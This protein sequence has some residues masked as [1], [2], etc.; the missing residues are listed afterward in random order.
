MKKSVAIIGGGPSALLLAAFLDD[1]KFDVSIYEK[2]AA[3]GRKF[4][5]AGKGG[6]NLTHSE[7]MHQFLRRYT[8]SD[9][10]KTAL[11][12]FTNEDLRVWL[13]DIGIETYIGSSKRVY[14]VKGIKPIQVL[15]TFIDVLKKKNVTILLD[16]EWKGWDKSNALLF[17]DSLRINADVVVFAL[18]GG[19]W[20]VT[21]SAGNWLSMFQE[22]GIKTIPFLPSNCAYE[23]DW[24]SAFVTNY[25]GTPLKN[26]ALTCR[27][28][29]QKGEVV[30]TSFG[31]EGNAIYALSPRI[32]A[33]LEQHNK[34]TIHLDLKPSLEFDTVLKKLQS[35][36]GN[37]STRLKQKLKLTPA[38]IALVKNS[39]TK[40]E[41][42]HL[43][44]LTEKIKAIPITI[45]SAGPV[46]AA[47]STVGGVSLD[48]VNKTFEL[49]A[50]PN[51]YCL[52]EMLNWDAPTGGYLL[53]ACFSMGVN[54]A[55]EL[56]KI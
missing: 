34:A 30:I 32:R 36:T 19:S 55:N 12:S 25:E 40:E 43:E 10:L 27:K 53:Q 13:N 3:L 47:I 41:F 52:G 39:C 50:L 21:G 1:S 14:P 28:N 15:N 7:P 8:P 51:H 46:D 16:H 35:A 9:F 26:I 6:F 31:L 45:V 11:E 37:I 23:V 24:S 2:N 22:K 20:K 44:S 5:V 42:I 54:L 33:E 56:N 38:Q 4:L 18:G 49:K 29:R 48:S 17:N